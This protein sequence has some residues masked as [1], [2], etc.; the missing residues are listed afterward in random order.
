VSLLRDLWEGNDYSVHFAVPGI[1]SIDQDLAAAQVV[2]HGAAREPKGFYRTHGIWL[3][4]L[5]RTDKGWI[6]QPH[7]SI[8]LAGLVSFGGDTFPKCFSEQ[9]SSIIDTNAHLPP[10]LRAR[11]M[12]SANVRHKSPLAI[13]VAH[14]DKASSRSTAIVWSELCNVSA[15]NVHDLAGERCEALVI[16]PF[17]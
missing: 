15:C 10:E 11:G 5:S 1:I 14:G 3:D 2:R 8:R 12:V 7:F 4:Y 17:C 6:H 13:S 16:E 9:P